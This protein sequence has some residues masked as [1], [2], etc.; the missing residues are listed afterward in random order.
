[1]D[2]VSDH[3]PAILNSSIICSSSLLSESLIIFFFKLRSK[4]TA[5]EGVGARWRKLE[6]EREKLRLTDSTLEIGM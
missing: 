3:T 6:L 2:N 1:M 4:M 5:R